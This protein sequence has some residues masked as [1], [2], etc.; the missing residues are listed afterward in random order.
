M[1]EEAVICDGCERP[2]DLCECLDICRICGQEECDGH[3]EC[4]F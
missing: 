2:V 3:E 1:K 4:P